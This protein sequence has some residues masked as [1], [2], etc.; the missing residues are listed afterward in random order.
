[1]SLTLLEGACTVT[2]ERSLEMQ[3]LGWPTESKPSPELPDIKE[4]N[5][6][7]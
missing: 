6:G 5:G 3:C 1:V 7:H 4:M 2:M